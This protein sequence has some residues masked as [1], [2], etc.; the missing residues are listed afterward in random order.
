MK[1]ATWVKRIFCSIAL[2]N[3][4]HKRPTTQYLLSNSRKSKI[5]PFLLSLINTVFKPYLI[6][7]EIL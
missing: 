6:V 3:P 2:C 4:I 7:G 5:T 1:A